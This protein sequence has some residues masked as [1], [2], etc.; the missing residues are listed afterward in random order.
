MKTIQEKI[1]E[2]KK[3]K[4]AIILAHYYTTPDIQEIADFSGDSLA[5]AQKAK[6]GGCDAMVFAGVNFMAETAK[7]LNPSKRVFIP[8]TRS[9]CSLADSCNVEDFKRFKEQYP[10]HKVVTYI[11][12][13]SEMKTV[14]DV[15]C[16]SGNALK[17]VESFPKEQ[18]LIFAPDRNLG[19]YINRVTGRDMILWNGACHVHDQMKLENIF[20][21]KEQHPDAK[22]LAH[23]ECKDVITKAADFVGSTK[24]MLEFTKKDSAKKYIV[25]TESGIFYEMKKQS[26]DKEFIFATNEKTCSC[27][28]CMYMKLNT[29]EKIYDCLLNETNEVILSD[30]I[31]EKARHSIEKMLMLS[32]K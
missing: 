16:T 12:C 17:I 15:I 4:N 26:P 5:L 32:A 25:A 13:S 23:P 18:P 1:Q 24:A 19:G 31:I 6:K 2:L 9:G 14:S 3:Q 28:D 29:L 8:D 27:D 7:I 30:E 11:N 10:N 21:L 20:R 22:I